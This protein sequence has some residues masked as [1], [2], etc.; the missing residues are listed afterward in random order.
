MEKIVTVENIEFGLKASAGT[1]RRYR[2]IF[3]RDLIQDMGALEEDIINNK[4]VTPN[5]ANIV[6]NVSWIMAKEYNND[7]PEATE[8]LSQF[9]PF[10]IYSIASDVIRMWTD[11]LK[12]LNQSKKK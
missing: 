7:I 11:N 8:W 1:V 10:F 5:T 4:T 6:E 3:A 9:S 12:T 2:D